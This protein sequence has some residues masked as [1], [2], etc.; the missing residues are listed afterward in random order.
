MNY[1]SLIPSSCVDF[2]VGWSTVLQVSHCV[3]MCEGCFNVSSWTKNAGEL[4]TED[5]Y[6]ELLSYASKPYISNI[7]MQGGDPLSPLNYKDMITLC[8]RL[9]KELPDKNIVLF[10]GYTYEQLQNDLLR[11][12]CLETIDFLMDGCYE[13]DNPTSK[14]FRGS[15]NQVL[16][17]IVNGVSV[18]KM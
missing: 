6:Q 3:H 16:H 1:M 5:T 12:S 9:K 18:E 2:G 4:F 13:K 11:Q 10:T 17:R 8:R 14:P 7:V 15:H